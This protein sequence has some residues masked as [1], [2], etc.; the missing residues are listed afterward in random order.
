[1]LT[2]FTLSSNHLEPYFIPECTASQSLHS[3]S[4]IPGAAGAA[5]GSFTQAV[6]EKM[7][8]NHKRPV[9]F[10][11]S[12]PTNL[13]ECTAEQAYKATKVGEGRPAPLRLIRTG[14]VSRIRSF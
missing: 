7:A 9:I 2:L 8:H 5:P 11:L 3:S 6:L 4:L 13:S 14:A 10:A 1:M 12:N